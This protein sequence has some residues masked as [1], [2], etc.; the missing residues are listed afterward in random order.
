ML[1]ALIMAGGFGTRFWPES[2]AGR[3]KQFLPLA[4]PG[5]M[6]Q[7]AYDRLAGLIDPGHVIVATNERFV[8]LVK[9]QLP[10]LAP[11]AIL[12]E[13]CRRDTAPCIGLAAMEIRRRDADATM[14]VLP[15]DQ[16]IQ[17]TAEFQAAAR[18][19]AAI[20]DRDPQCFATFG[21]QP[22]RPAVSYGYIECGER[23]WELSDDSSVVAYR[24]RAFCEKPPE[25]IARQYVAGGKH[26]WNAGIF[27]WKAAA[28]LES[29]AK[30]E[31]D[32]HARLLVIDAARHSAEYRETLEREFAAMRSV[33]IDYAIMERATNV[34]V[35]QAPFEWDDVGS[36]QSLARLHGTDADGNTILGKHL[37][38]N[39]SGTIVRNTENHLVVT[40]GLKDCLIVHAA[41]VTLV[42]DKNQ[43]DQVRKL[44]QLVEELGLR[45][46]L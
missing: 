17:P 16:V 37:G 21:I 9:E 28:V 1:H 3:P 38:R 11:G 13:P 12:G 42:A 15:A 32:L 22:T 33:S 29:L 41:D 36:W 35:I 44:V 40:L 34:V 24:A 39:T 10:G 5:T 8:D 20:V 4:G 30:H 27:I 18:V 26:L 6:L 43:E 31:P 45:D 19:A 25:E 14:V 23:V 7:A 2:R 46:R